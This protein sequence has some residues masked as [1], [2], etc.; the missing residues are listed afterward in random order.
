M[1]EACSSG[2]DSP[3][4]TALLV[5]PAAPGGCA[6]G[7]RHLRCLNALHDP[8]CGW[9]GGSLPRRSAPRGGAP[10]ADPSTVSRPRRPEP[11]G[12]LRLRAMTALMVCASQVPGGASGGGGAAVHATNSATGL[13]RR[14]NSP[15]PTAPL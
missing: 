5:S 6:Q 3:V 7:A 8:R 15:P 4:A 2:P 11:A 13:Q 10:G 14:A 1:M 12:A 9:C